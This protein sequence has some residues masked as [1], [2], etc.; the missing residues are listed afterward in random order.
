MR[1]EKRNFNKLCFLYGGVIFLL[2]EGGEGFIYF[3]RRFYAY[4]ICFFVMLT[5]VFIDRLVYTWRGLVG[6]KIV[7]R[8]DIADFVVAQSPHYKVISQQRTQRR[9]I[10]VLQRRRKLSRRAAVKKLGNIC[11]VS[12]LSKRLIA[13]LSTNAVFRRGYILPRVYRLIIAGPGVMAT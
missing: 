13:S 1:R 9:R 6:Q 4:R 7:R 10:F 8:Y 12:S 5:A 2:R 3:P 11:Q